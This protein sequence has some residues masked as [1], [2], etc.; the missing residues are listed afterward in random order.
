MANGPMI[1]PR[2]SNLGI[3]SGA[4]A[5][6][7]ADN[8]GVDPRLDLLLNSV[9]QYRMLQDLQAAEQEEPASAIQRLLSPA[10]LAALGL[11]AGA[12]ALG[13]PQAG[14]P[15]LSGVMGGAQQAAQ[16]EQQAQQD[17]I[18]KLEDQI[19]KQRTRITTLLQ[20]QPGI[21]L[22]NQGQNLV[23]PQAL[24]P[25]A[26]LPFPVSPASKFAMMTKTEGQKGMY[27]VLSELMKQ[28]ETDEARAVVLET[29]NVM[30]D[31]GLPQEAI[32]V[33]A[34]PSNQR[35]L[36]NTLIEH[37]DTN[38]LS[39]ALLAAQMQGVDLFHPD[40]MPLYMGKLRTPEVGSPN[41]AFTARM[42]EAA[43]KFEAWL[44][45]PDGEPF[46][47]EDTAIAVDAW[48][49]SEGTTADAGFLRSK[50][51]FK[52]AENLTNEQLLSNIM[53]TMQ[54]FSIVDAAMQGVLTDPTKRPE[55]FQKIME[56][57]VGVQNALRRQTEATELVG[58]S[59]DIR[60]AWRAKG[61][62][63]P[64]LAARTQEAMA[65]VKELLGLTRLS[66][67]NPDELRNAVRM[68]IQSIEAGDQ[69]E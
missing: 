36:F 69:G 10:G 12:T 27:P 68:V 14:L 66:E 5:G 60:A 52:G 29:M 50:G 30:M 21:F 41:E 44:R 4:Q 43:Q 38:A 62:E 54:Q 23:D 35:E 53:R 56:D 49:A 61:F 7:A 1:H 8:L 40:I 11:G 16:E 20:A 46:R 24:G 39:D 67:A 15:F 42:L 13:A 3:E 37:F 57:Q 59:N 65:K 6:Q 2:L 18:A 28:A 63:G 25:L 31:L 47:A 64:E 55:Y 58:H 34:R 45:S 17:Y 33:F 22:D 9:D 19:E 32:D 51:G 48:V 26:G